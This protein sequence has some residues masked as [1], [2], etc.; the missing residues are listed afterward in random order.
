VGFS[1]GSAWG[2]VLLNA[3]DSSNSLT[4]GLPRLRLV[5]SAASI[6]ATSV[7]RMTDVSSPSGFLTG[8]GS[9]RQSPLSKPIA[10]S[11]LGETKE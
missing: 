11:H 5:E 3:V 4:S 9:S 1:S 7:V 8:S 2:W 10:S 6:D